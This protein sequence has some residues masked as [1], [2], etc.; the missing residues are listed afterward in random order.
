SSS[1][2]EWCY[3]TGPHQGRCPTEPCCPG[4]FEPCCPGVFEPCCPGVFEPCCPGVFE[5]CCPGVFEPCCPGVFEPCCPGVFD[6]AVRQIA[7]E[8][9][10]HW[11]HVPVAAEPGGHCCCPFHVPYQGE[12]TQQDWCQCLQTWTQFWLPPS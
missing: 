12:E 9:D 8:P 10:R 4:V 11:C 3:P 2:Q 7:T 6:P 5:P 1:S